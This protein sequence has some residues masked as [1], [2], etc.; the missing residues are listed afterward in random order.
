[1]RRALIAA[2]SLALLALVPAAARPSAEPTP[3]ARVGAF[4]FDGWAGPLTSFHFG[5]L[6][7]TQFSG[8]RPLSG[9]RDN[10]PEAL[11]AQ[12]R[13][14]HEDGIGFF[15]FD[16][17]YN[18]DPGN[19]PINMAHDTYL[20][21]HD[22]DG[23][24]YA[25][26]YVNQPGFVV[27]PDQWATV[28]DSWVTQDFLNP[29]Y[30]RIDGKPLLVI[31]DERFFNLQMGGATGV[32]AAIA[33][34]QEAGKRHGLPGVFVVGGRYLTWTSE[35]CFPQCQDTDG[36]SPLEHYD[37][38]TEFS[39]PYILEPRDGPRP[40]SEVA[41]AIERMWEVIAQRSPFPHI[42]SVM[43]GFDARPMILAGQIQ[44]PDQGGWPLLKGHETWFVTTPADVGGLVRDAASWVEAHPSMRVEPAPAPPV[45]LIQSWNELQ[46]GAILV[47]TDQDGY[48]YGRAIA[49]AVG[50][51]WTPPPKHTLRVATSVRGTVTSAP[52]GI[53]CPPI[54]AAEFDEGLQVTLTA[55]AKR[56]S[57]LDRWRGCTD[58]DPTCSVVLVGDSTVRP[59]FLSTVQRR[60]LSLRFSRRLVARGR[61]SV[62]DGFGGCVS[63]EQVQ[64]QRRGGR[65]WVSV[66]S[67]QTDDAGRYTA[68]MRDRP[69]A[70]RARAAQDSLEGHTCLV[71]TS[72]TVNYGR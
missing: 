41:A 10:T 29:D 65:G 42:P 16:W 4:Y 25:L 72:R 13:W 31:L 54:C 66:T 11:E 50:I 58:T 68:K 3:S 6:L 23:V 55:S 61:L 20:K 12:L 35:Q 27:P 21:L 33:T 49:Q 26:N 64:I 56:G 8:R 34:L 22:H 59:V 67:T 18:P 39:Y 51:P 36:D 47:P 28:A 57:V 45:V 5:G 63:S 37:A 24:G 43:A 52:A 69:G 14:A 7:G 48:S 19:G 40:Y 1:M 53:S 44:S 15:A 32:N 17:Y 9:W 60:T 62:R 46:E 71:T 70:Y 30:V 38:I 2:A